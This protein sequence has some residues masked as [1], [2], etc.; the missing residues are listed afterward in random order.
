MFGLSMCM[1][2]EHMLHKCVYTFFVD[3]DNREAN[4]QRKISPGLNVRREK[5]HRTK[6]SIEK[7]LG[8]N[9]ITSQ[10]SSAFS[11]VHS[12]MRDSILLTYK[13]IIIC[14]HE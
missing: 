6:R 14:V 11:F 9:E 4:L 1:C 5:K 3:T 10:S 8:G 13:G 7:E 2:P 12:F